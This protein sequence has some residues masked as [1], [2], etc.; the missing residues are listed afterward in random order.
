MKEYRAYLLDAER[1]I[2]SR[3]DLMCEDDAE[4][5]SEAQQ[6]TDGY[7]V[8]VWQGQRRVRKLS[9]S[10]PPFTRQ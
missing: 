3:V 6:H 8:E 9:G 1:H 2:L 4:A 10:R 7:D 5:V